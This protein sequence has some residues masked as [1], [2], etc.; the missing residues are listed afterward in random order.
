MGIYI[1]TTGGLQRRSARASELEVGVSGGLRQRVYLPPGQVAAAVGEVAAGTPPLSAAELLQSAQAVLLGRELPVPVL[2][3]RALT[4][5]LCA[6][7]LHAVERALKSPEVM[8]HLQGTVVRQNHALGVVAAALMGHAQAELQEPAAW[9]A[10]GKRLASVA[11][12][13]VA[14]MASVRKKEKDAKGNARKRHQGTAAELEER[15][16]TIARTAAEEVAA[17]RGRPALW[18]PDGKGRAAA[19]A[20]SNAVAGLVVEGP[21]ITADMQEAAASLATIAAPAAAAEAPPRAW[22]CHRCLE[23]LREKAE[24]CEV[25]EAATHAK[26]IHRRTHAFGGVFGCA[27]GEAAAARARRGARG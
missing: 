8:A 27:G 2:P 5:G 26:Q 14:R 3:P 21:R 13:H 22:S 20:A 11:R 7:L 10:A 19:P 9:E 1:H 24:A 18:L 12:P 16:A 25:A 4:H 23:L 6:D 17:C 15:L